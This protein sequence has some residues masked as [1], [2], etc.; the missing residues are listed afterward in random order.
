MRKTETNRH[1]IFNIIHIKV[2]QRESILQINYSETTTSQRPHE[3]D[4]RASD[5]ISSMRRKDMG[6]SSTALHS[7]VV[8]GQTYSDIYTGVKVKL[9]LKSTHNKA[10]CLIREYI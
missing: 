8:G 2:Y 10:I 9:T 7:Y 6:V 5:E 4:S 1:K 3:E